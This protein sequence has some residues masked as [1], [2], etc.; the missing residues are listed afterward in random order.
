M[1]IL[2]IATDNFKFYY[3]MV[4]ELKQR[5]IPFVSLSPA[6][7]IPNTVDVVVTTE[8][9]SDAIEFDNIVSVDDDIRKGVRE[10]LS[11]L[12]GKISYNHMIV[13]VDPGTKPGVALVGDGK[14]LETEYADSPEDVREI[15]DHYIEGYNFKRMTIKIGH[16]DK[17]NRNRTINSLEGLAA[18]KEIVNEDDTTILGEKPDLEAAK[19]IALTEG[20][21]LSGTYEIEA[22]DGEM[23]EIQ[24]RS[25]IKSVGD[26]TISKKLAKKVVEGE[27]N[28]KQAIKKQKDK[29][30]KEKENQ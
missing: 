5:D 13:G 1:K 8:K 2:A 14:L 26:I 7:K 29:S 4:K 30:N 3:D 20:Q 19:K 27:L 6:D 21:L 23:R 11:R 15:I 10:A 17:T 28:L 18:R 25:R 9:E 12:S 16:G 24:R 22:T